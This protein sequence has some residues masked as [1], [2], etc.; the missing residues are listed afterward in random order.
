MWLR[1]IEPLNLR[2]LDLHPNLCQEGPEG[3]S[4]KL[5]TLAAQTDMFVNC[6]FTGLHMH[7]AAMS[8]F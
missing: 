2:F 7:S 1:G 4:Q 6:D 5:S 8:G 3:I